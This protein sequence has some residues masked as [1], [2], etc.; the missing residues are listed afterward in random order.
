[1]YSFLNFSQTKPKKAVSVSMM[2]EYLSLERG[3][4]VEVEKD[5]AIG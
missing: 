3:L 5:N 2:N 4:L 1:M